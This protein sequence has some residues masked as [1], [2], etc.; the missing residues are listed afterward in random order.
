VVRDI[1]FGKLSAS[2]PFWL[3]LR[4]SRAGLESSSFI[5]SWI[6]ACAGMTVVLLNGKNIPLWKKF[7]AF[8]VCVGM[9]F[10]CVI[11]FFYVV[12]GRGVLS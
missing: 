3:V 10:P 2:D 6:S 5:K 7:V 1:F 12:G 4:Y 8:A 9:F 11:A